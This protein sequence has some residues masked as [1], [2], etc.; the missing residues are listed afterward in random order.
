MP[1]SSPQ[2]NYKRKE[3][4]SKLGF[5]SKWQRKI[6]HERSHLHTIHIHTTD[7]KQK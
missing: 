2:R 4:N 7:K 5:C 6:T 3:N 1:L